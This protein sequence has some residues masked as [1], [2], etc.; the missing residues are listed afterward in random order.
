MGIDLRNG[1]GLLRRSFRR[2]RRL[3][4]SWFGRARLD[5][6]DRRNGTRD[7]LLPPRR[8]GLPSQ[9]PKVGERLADALADAGRLA[10]GGAVLDIGCGP[11][12]VAAPLARY[13][14]TEGRYEGFDVMPRSIRWCRRAISSRHP[15]FRFQLADL[16][17]AQ[18]NPGGSYE[19]AEYVFPYADS[20]FDAAL[21]GSLFTHL[22]PFEGERYLEQTARV[23]RPGGRLLG[24]WFLL[25]DES[26]ALL[27]Q[28][29][30]RR[31]AMLAQGP[32][33]LGDELNDRRG[34]RFRSPRSDLPEFMIAIRESDV[35]AMHE[36]AGL[37]IVATRYGAW[38]GRES[39][40]D[41]LGQ[42]LLVAERPA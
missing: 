26:E 30:G 15:N 31:Q 10:P 38:P 1:P 11:G 39:E 22:Q 42:D 24:T 18:Y 41:G 33:V 40:P 17:N 23:L 3:V 13:L 37:R 28:G 20:S 32:L 2:R 5:L 36:R 29:L 21:A 34:N 4:R 19:A 8:L 27:D 9:L 14:S 6:G 12:R 35:V 25:N 7:P 16:R